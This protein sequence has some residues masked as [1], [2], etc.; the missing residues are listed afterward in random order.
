[1][2]SLKIKTGW[3]QGFAI[4]NLALAKRLLNEISE[5]MFNPHHHCSNKKTRINPLITIVLCIKDVN[6]KKLNYK[7]RSL[8]LQKIKIN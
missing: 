6:K 4:F 7:D 8:Y 5:N 2:I 3:N 1:M